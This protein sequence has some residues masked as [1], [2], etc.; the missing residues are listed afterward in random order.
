MDDETKSKANGA[1]EL[2]REHVDVHNAMVLITENAVAK[3]FRQH[4]WP[5]TRENM[6]VFDVNLHGEV[7]ELWEAFRDGRI[8]ARCDK[9]EKMEAL[10]L[11]ALTC[12]EEEIADIIIRALDTANALGV[13][14]RRAIAVKHAYNTTRPILHG[15]KLA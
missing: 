4:P 11:P 5:I 6:A 8:N 13:D 10:G 14:V 2:M 3:V 9:A 7:S 1:Y 12:A 15:G